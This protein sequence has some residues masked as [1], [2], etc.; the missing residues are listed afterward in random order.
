MIPAKS[1]SDQRTYS[2]TVNGL[3]GIAGEARGSP[4]RSPAETGP[5]IESQP[6]AA[7]GNR[8]AEIEAQQPAGNRE[9]ESRARQDARRKQL[10]RGTSLS[11]VN[12]RHW[13]DQTLG[14]RPVGLC[15]PEGLTSAS[16]VIEAPDRRHAA[17]PELLLRQCRRRCD[18]GLEREHRPASSPAHWL[19]QAREESPGRG[20]VAGEHVGTQP[21]AA[22]ES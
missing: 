22:A 6:V 17:Q 7:V 14:Q 20:P 18:A 19:P 1:T 3:A 4:D 16:P 12:E 8:I 15:R 21:P 2:S 5:D 10:V 9:S 11:H 13:A